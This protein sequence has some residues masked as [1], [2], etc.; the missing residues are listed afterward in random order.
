MSTIINLATPGVANR[1][2]AYL[3]S[4]SQYDVVKTRREC[5]TY[6]FQNIE[7]ASDEELDMYPHENGWRL[8]VQE[9]EKQYTGEYEYIDLLYD[10]TPKYFID[11]YL[12]ILSQLKINPDILNYVNEFTEGWEKN[13]IAVHIR[14]WYCERRAWHSNELFENEIDKLDPDAKIFLCSDNSDVIKHFSD[15]HKD[16]II[17]H[18]QESFSHP[19]LAESGFN[20]SFQANADALIDMLI[21]SKCATIIGTYISTFAEVAWW[22]G[23]CKSKVIIPIPPNVPAH[24][25]EETFKRKSK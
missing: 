11:K 20:Y 5:D 2:K 14:S 13:T 17:L 1:I 16:R 22:F 21:L 7:L 9:D 25:G 6:L 8:F 19:H 18:P 4:M 24:I 10:K 23:G 15:R 12:G 3:S